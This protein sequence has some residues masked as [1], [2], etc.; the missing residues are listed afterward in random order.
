MLSML[1]NRELPDQFDKEHVRAVG[2]LFGEPELC[3]CTPASPFKF[4]DVEA[5]YE[6]HC[7]FYNHGPRVLE[8]LKAYTAGADRDPQRPTVGLAGHVLVMGCRHARAVPKTT[9]IAT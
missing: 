5:T 9:S 7:G 2:S 1:N 4:P 6:L 8:S 3:G